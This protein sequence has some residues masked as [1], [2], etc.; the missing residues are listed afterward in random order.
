MNTPIVSQTT[1]SR[2]QQKLAD[3]RTL[4]AFLEANPRVPIGNNSG[5]AEYCIT[6]MNVDDAA[7]MAELG[8]IAAALGVEITHN[9]DETQ[10]FA[11]RHFGTVTYTAFYCTRA[12]MKRYDEEQSWVRERRKA[13][14]ICS[15]ENRA[16]GI[17]CPQH[18]DLAGAA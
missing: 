9:G 11:R 17:E 15:Q 3:L 13:Q 8:D 7:G 6:G 12:S 4:V 5:P 1:D 14:C 10:H 18:S 2:R 16:A